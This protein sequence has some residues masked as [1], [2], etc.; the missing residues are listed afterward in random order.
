MDSL[1][2]RDQEWR[3]ILPE[4][5]SHRLSEHLF[6]GDRDEHGAIIYAGLHVTSE[7][8]VRLLGRELVLAQDGTDYVESE[9]AHRKLRAQFIQEHIRRCREVGLVYLAVHNHRLADSVAFSPKDLDSHRR[10][11]PALVDINYPRPVGAL[12]SAGRAV[13]GE[14]WLSSDVQVALATTEV[15]G[16]ARTVL[17]PQPRRADMMSDQTYDRQSRLFGDAGQDILKGCRVGIIGLGGVGSLIAEY[18]GR[19]GVGKFVLVDPDRIDVTNLPR[20]VGAT[21]EDALFEIDPSATERHLTTPKVEI[22]ERVILQANPRASVK[23]IMDDVQAAPSASALLDCDYLFL[24]ADSM[25]AR[26]IFNQIV[27]Q[28][29]IPGVQIG[30]KVSTDQRSGE[31]TDVFSVVRPV[32]PETGCLWCNQVINPAKLQT[33]AQGEAE[34]RAQRYVDEPEV[35]APSVITLNAV[36]AAHAVNDF[37]FYMTGMAEP[38]ASQAYMLHR[39]RTRQTTWMQ[40]RKDVNCPECGSGPQGRLAKGD[41]WP[42]TTKGGRPIA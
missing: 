23:S 18:L 28:Y 39:P 7:G 20:V 1:A 36:G 9:R 15:I 30:S 10:G 3:L 11:Y 21:Q 25:G 5:M 17:T 29:L 4:G 37:L 2:L 12:V 38:E 33:E 26:L 32:S 41:A 35:V 42:L 34:R 27:H 6:P 22:A 16:R 24:A 13:A 31:V 40:P 8:I 19:L 14:I